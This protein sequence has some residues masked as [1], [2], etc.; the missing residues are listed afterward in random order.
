ML[1]K[2]ST[3]E[4]S[5][6]MASKELPILVHRLWI[7]IIALLW[8]CI[9]FGYGYSFASLFLEHRQVTMKATP[10]QKDSKSGLC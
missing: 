2:C 4:Y 10:L 7:W 8:V 9:G 5:L 1:T 3:V 6:Q